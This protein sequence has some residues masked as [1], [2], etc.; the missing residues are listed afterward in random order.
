MPEQ[1][2]KEAAQP[3]ST[4]VVTCRLEVLPVSLP[5]QLYHF[6]VPQLLCLKAQLLIGLLEAA[7]SAVC[8]W[9]GVKDRNEHAKCCKVWDEV[10]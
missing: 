10:Y 4:S 2:L 6:Q 8:C 5:C 3:L 9:P 7:D 1:P